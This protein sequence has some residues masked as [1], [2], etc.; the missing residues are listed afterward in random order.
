[1]GRGQLGNASRRSS[2]SFPL[3]QQQAAAFSDESDSDE[4]NAVCLDTPIAVTVHEAKC[5][6]DVQWLGRMDPYA[7]AMTAPSRN[8]QRRTRAA[9]NGDIAPKWAAK[10]AARTMM[11]RPG[12]EDWAVRVELWNENLLKVR[13]SLEVDALFSPSL[14]SCLCLPDMLSAGR[15]HRRGH[16]PPRRPARCLL[17]SLL[18]AGPGRAYAT[19]CEDDGRSVPAA[20]GRE[21]RRQPQCGDAEQGAALAEC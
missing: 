16:R 9:D 10:G 7:H 17:T 3:S 11:L 19:H 18:A 8:S 15:F 1:M 2:V 20:R 13:P 21:P 4:E 6:P 14:I 5:L 12:P